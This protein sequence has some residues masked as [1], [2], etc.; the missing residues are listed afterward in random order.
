MSVIDRA[1][2]DSCVTV[3]THCWGCSHRYWGWRRFPRR[4]ARSSVSHVFASTLAE[5]HHGRGPFEVLQRP[6]L[7][8]FSPSQL[9]RHRTEEQGVGLESDGRERNYHGIKVSDYFF[10]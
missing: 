3:T 9:L 2:S 7:S 4:F 1:S 6:E 10:R 8:N 5:A